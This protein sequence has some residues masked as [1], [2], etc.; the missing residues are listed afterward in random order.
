MSLVLVMMIALPVFAEADAET[1]RH[2][3]IYVEIG[4]EGEAGYLGLANGSGFFV[5][6]EGDNPEYI[7]T[8]YHVVKDFIKLGEGKKQTEKPFQ[9]FFDWYTKD[10]AGLTDEEINAMSDEDFESLRSTVYNELWKKFAGNSEQSTYRSIIRVYF[11]DRE[12]EDVYLKAKGDETRD[13]ALLRLSQPT[14]KRIP[15]AICKPSQNMVGKTVLAIGYPGSASSVFEPVSDKGENAAT[16]TDGRV[17]NVNEEK[18]TK[19][20]YVQTNAAV[21]YGN[22][23]G[24]LVLEENGAVIAI[25]T[26]GTSADDNMF[27]CVSSKELIDM[28]DSNSVQYELKSDPFG[29][30]VSQKDETKDDITDTSTQDS[31]NSSSQD[32]TDDNTND[33]T[34]DTTD[35]TTDIEDDA[36]GITIFGTTFTY[37]QFILGLVALIAAVAAIVLAVRHFKGKNDDE[38]DDSRGRSSG[39]DGSGEAETV[40]SDGGK[41]PGGN[42]PGQSSLNG[43]N[44]PPVNPVNP[45]SP[46]PD[47]SL[48]RIQCVRGVLGTMRVSIPKHGQVVMGRNEGCGIKFP[49]NT[50]GVSGRHCA[51]Y[52]ENGTVFIKDIGSTYGTFVEPG[53]RLAAN[54]AAMLREGQKFWLGSEN[55]CFVIDRKKR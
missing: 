26:W 25:N 40:V 41:G 19:L 42:G 24:P 3:V 44:V 2:S 37:T 10:C 35:D 21:S 18:G 51:V 9:N 36:E 46:I 20:E 22:S 38:E 52:F 23:G 16:V 39:S 12:F 55:E 15:I 13:I 31:T 48:L 1:M 5:G 49:S 30:T 27:F 53:K 11:D 7:V 6:K 33:N 29:S 4:C 14:D 28:L 54:E 8:N 17:S 47:D 32:N 34:N 45:V 43:G 50:K